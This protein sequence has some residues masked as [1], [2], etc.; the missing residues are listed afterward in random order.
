MAPGS[1][2][3]P[4]TVDCTFNDEKQA[5]ITVNKNVN[6]ATDTTKFSFTTT[7][8]GYNAFDLQTGVTLTNAEWV[9]PGANLHGG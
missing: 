4:E 8:A 7:G 3:V 5:L 2:W 1:K 9:A 6:P